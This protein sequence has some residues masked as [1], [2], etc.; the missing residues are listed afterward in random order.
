MTRSGWLGRLPKRR[1]AASAKDAA[2]FPEWRRPVVARASYYTKT[3]CLRHCFCFPPHGSCNLRSA[4]VVADKA[5]G[6]AGEYSAI[7]VCQWHGPLAP[8]VNG[9][10]ALRESF[11]IK[12]QKR[13]RRRGIPRQCRGLQRQKQHRRHLPAVMFWRPL[14][15]WAFDDKRFLFEP[16]GGAD[17]MIASTSPMVSGK[18]RSGCR[19]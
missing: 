1:S 19:Q 9:A 6:T 14:S 18:D 4:A 16:A 15:V 11:N 10:F 13:R 5:A 8:T 2:Q 12:K 17:M 3:I 7:D